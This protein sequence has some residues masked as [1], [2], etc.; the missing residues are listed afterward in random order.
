M[1]SIE[2]TQKNQTRVKKSLKDRNQKN[3]KVENQQTKILQKKTYIYN[4]CFKHLSRAIKNKVM[5]NC[6]IN[7]K[8]NIFYGKLYLDLELNVADDC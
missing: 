1:S 3:F 6:T 2:I 7:I 5:E 4:N 8:E